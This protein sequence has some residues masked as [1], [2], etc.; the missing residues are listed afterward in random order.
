MGKIHWI[1]LSPSSVYNRIQA[2]YKPELSTAFYCT[3]E[4][5]YT[6]IT[7][8]DFQ[9]FFMCVGFF[10]ISLKANLSQIVK[11]GHGLSTFKPASATAHLINLQCCCNLV[12]Y[13]WYH[14]SVLDVP[15]HKI[16]QI[17]LAGY[18]AGKQSISS[19]LFLFLSVTPLWHSDP[20]CQAQRNRRNCCATV[21]M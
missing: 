2:Q 17:R 9:V 5:R 14:H 7:S 20:A 12:L 1:P 13:F 19:H 16:S 3:D 4:P 18:F 11:N 6:V 15:A 8:A 21:G 10:P